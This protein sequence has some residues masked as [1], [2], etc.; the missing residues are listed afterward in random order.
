[1]INI[2]KLLVLKAFYLGYEIRENH[3]NEAEALKL[4]NL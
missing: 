3:F 2:D 4:V 1:M